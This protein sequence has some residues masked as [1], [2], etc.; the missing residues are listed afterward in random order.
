MRQQI[1]QI[2][3]L[4]GKWL[5][6]VISSVGREQLLTSSEGI[7]LLIDRDL[8]NHWDANYDIVFLSG[9]NYAQFMD[10]L[11]AVGKNRSWLLE[12]LFLL[13]GT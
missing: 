6:S 10:R 12:I 11:L 4:L 8:P 3:D 9:S 2:W 1:G 13:I 5:D 7:D